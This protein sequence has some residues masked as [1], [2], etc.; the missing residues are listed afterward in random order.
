MSTR[1][2]GRTSWP[3]AAAAVLLFWQTWYLLHVY[4]T[5]RSGVRWTCDSEGCGTNQLAGGAL[6]LAAPS[7]VGAA[8]LAAPF[9]GGPAGTGLALLLASFGLFVGREDDHAVLAAHGLAGL[10]AVLVVAGAA[11]AVRRRGSSEPAPVPVEA[12]GRLPAHVLLR[13][14]AAPATLLVAV[15]GTVAVTALVHGALDGPRWVMML[16]LN[17]TVGLL[18]PLGLA[19]LRHRPGVASGPVPER[20][21]A[22]APARLHSLTSR[23]TAFV[24][25]LTV[26]PDGGAPYR[27]EVEHPLDLQDAR[28]HRAAVVRHD[29][30][31]PWRVDL[32]QHPPAAVL[33]RARAAARAEDLPPAPRLRTPAPGAP[34]VVLTALFTAALVTLLA[35]A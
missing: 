24:F 6:F 8:L 5:E 7:A 34:A 10:G 13:L 25:D 2:Y 15:P 21:A 11:R 18:I 32:P 1:A 20:S 22:H 30:R 19:R 29:P 31:R 28:T 33:T 3:W 9:L 35:M 14:L 26:E 4:A 23:G 12:G 16:G 27:I 17:A